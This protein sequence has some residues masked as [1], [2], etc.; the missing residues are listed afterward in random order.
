MPAAASA[1]RPPPAGSTL[2]PL[3]PQA[4]AAA[5]VSVALHAKRRPRQ[6]LRA[7]RNVAHVHAPTRRQLAHRAPAPPPPPEAGEG[8]YRLA[9]A[10]LRG[11]MGSTVVVNACREAKGRH[12][13]KGMG[14]AQ[15][16]GSADNTAVCQGPRRN[17]PLNLV[18]LLNGVAG[19]RKR[20]G[21]GARQGPAGVRIQRQARRR[22]PG[23]PIPSGPRRCAPS[24]GLKAAAAL[25]LRTRRAAPRSQL[26]PV[27]GA[28]G[29]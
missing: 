2:P 8:A 22:P 4:S 25:L 5:L 21:Q 18:L 3:R 7:R 17:S 15:Q 26:R 27:G 29:R 12:P 13:S 10:T 1:G 6:A 23:P 11:R 9:L 20:K 16:E 19:A 28:R 14:Q 24:D